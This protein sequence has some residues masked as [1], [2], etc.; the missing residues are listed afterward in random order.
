MKIFKGILSQLAYFFLIFYSGPRDLGFNLMRPA[1][2][3]ELETPD[4]DRLVQ[5][6]NYVLGHVEQGE[7]VSRC[8]LQLSFCHLGD[9]E[10]Q[11][12]FDNSRRVVEG[13]RDCRLTVTRG[14]LLAVLRNH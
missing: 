10:T 6:N 7:S 13:D 1:R 4:L 12:F 9:I 5:K 8:R 3:F 11:S 14:H 2:Q